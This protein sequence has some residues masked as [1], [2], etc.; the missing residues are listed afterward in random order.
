MAT[1]TIILV[2]HGQYLS[3]PS[4]KLTTL[5]RKQA[6]L[7][8]RRLK[9]MKFHKIHFSTMP[10]AKETAEIITRTMGYGRKLHGSADLHE[11]LPGFPKKERKKHGHT[12]EKVFRK[13]KRQADR[14]YKEIFTFSKTNR[15]E[16]VVCHGNII[17]YFLCKTLGIDT[18]LWLKLDIKQCGITVIT[19]E[20]SKKY[21]RKARVVTHND[22]GHIPLKMQTFL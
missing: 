13:D 8:G 22:V 5:G 9:Q 20:D 15:T 7:A 14:A 11:C 1:K 21:R 4:E 2:R 17:R 12:D 19:L 16:L 10:R 6:V 3:K 18:E